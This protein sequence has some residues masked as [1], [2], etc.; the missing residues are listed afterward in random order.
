MDFPG[1][2]IVYLIA[3]HLWL[4]YRHSTST[5]SFQLFFYFTLSDWDQHVP[6]LECNCFF[7][8]S[9]FTGSKE[10]C[11]KTYNPCSSQV[12]L[13]VLYYVL[14]YAQGVRDQVTSN[15]HRAQS[16]QCAISGTSPWVNDS[17]HG[18]SY[19]GTQMCWLPTPL[20][21]SDYL[22]PTVFSHLQQHLREQTCSTMW[23]DYNLIY[24][25]F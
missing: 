11:W 15:Q 24:Q 16:D 13:S 23:P 20:V 17:E 19:P 14:P 4:L 22:K 5:C 21:K 6:H 25:A 7:S 1:H 3:Q 8:G 18:A 12:I 10:L 9:W 2:I